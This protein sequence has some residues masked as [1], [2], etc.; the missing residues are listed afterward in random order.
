MEN[1]ID[2]LAIA[3]RLIGIM[4]L[5]SIATKVF[6]I[7]VDKLNN[8]VKKYVSDFTIRILIWIAILANIAAVFVTVIDEILK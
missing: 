1:L 2:N 6:F 7:I 5:A 3:W 8:W 4:V